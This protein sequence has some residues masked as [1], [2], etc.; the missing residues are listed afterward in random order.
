MFLTSE[1]AHVDNK[2][3]VYPTLR[4]ST[5]ALDEAEDM[6]ATS[7]P[8]PADELLQSQDADGSQSYILGGY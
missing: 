6:E 1:S 5:A 3:H 2:L 4:R 8:H 7:E